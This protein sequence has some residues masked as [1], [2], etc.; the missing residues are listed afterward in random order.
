[1]STLSELEMRILSELEEAG[2]ED[3]VTMINTVM[4]CTGDVSEVRE[5]QSAL[6]NLVRADFVRMSI[7][8]DSSKRLRALTKEESLMVI[9]ELQ[10]HLR[11]KSSDGHWTD[12]RHTGPPYDW[13]YPY[14]VNTDSGREKGFEIL[15]ERGYQWWWQKR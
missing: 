14:I 10:S 12:E 7:D 6:E 8:Q 3:V 4:E 11:F 1:M 13:P 15:D 5:L 2:E 9:A